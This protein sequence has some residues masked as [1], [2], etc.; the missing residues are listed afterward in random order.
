VLSGGNAAAAHLHLA[1]TIA[2]RAERD[3]TA[4]MAAEAI[5]PACLRYVNR[6]SDLLFVMARYANEKGAADVLWVPGQNR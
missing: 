3:M 5:N 6:L 2:R 1:R 4:L